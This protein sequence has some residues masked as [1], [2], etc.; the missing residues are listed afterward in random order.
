MSENNKD[1]SHSLAEQLIASGVD[2]SQFF[3]KDGLLK[4]LTKSLLEN[5]L[6]GEMD[7]HLLA[8]QKVKGE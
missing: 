4:S 1:L 2:L 8:T 6:E 7:R 3:E 5:A